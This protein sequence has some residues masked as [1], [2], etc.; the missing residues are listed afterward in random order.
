[1][2]AAGLR[3]RREHRLGGMRY[4][5]HDKIALQRERKEEEAFHHGTLAWR[6]ALAT[7]TAAHL[8]FEQNINITA[9]YT[10]GSPK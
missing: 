4:A 3:R 6:C 7:V 10:Y 8:A 2:L 1:M 9:I 5:R